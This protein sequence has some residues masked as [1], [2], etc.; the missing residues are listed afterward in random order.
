MNKITKLT[1][2]IVAICVCACTESEVLTPESKNDSQNLTFGLNQVANLSRAD[3]SSFDMTTFC[4]E[5][6][7]VLGLKR[8]SSIKTNGFQYVCNNT[9]MYPNYTTYTWVP[10]KSIGIN[11]KMN[12]SFF[13]Y[14]PYDKNM[15]STVDANNGTVSIKLPKCR[16]INDNNKAID[17]II[18]HPM[19]D[20][21]GDIDWYS[22]KEKSYLP[23]TLY[24]AQSRVTVSF[25][26]HYSDGRNVSLKGARIFLPDTTQKSELICN[27]E[28]GETYYAD[29]A[30]TFTSATT[31]YEDYKI[32]LGDDEIAT[33]EYC[34]EFKLFDFHIT[35]LKDETKITKLNIELDLIISYD[36]TKVAADHI[37]VSGTIEIALKKNASYRTNITLHDNNLS[38]KAIELQSLV[39]TFVNDTY[40]Y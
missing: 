1:F 17:Y 19:M 7:G 6:M 12:Y 20:I 8:D 16:V 25:Y 31:L 5:K 4:R 28:I 27:L 21:S 34:K 32:E 36:D 2:A 9:L 39:P 40:L 3:R 10:Q 23:M 22:E 11:K 35:P 18:S 33:M 26:N 38:F 30:Y 24:H 29:T 14:G 13:T 15:E 37:S